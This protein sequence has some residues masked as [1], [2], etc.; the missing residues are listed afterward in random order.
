M[1]DGRERVDW[2]ASSE[3]PDIARG[4]AGDEELRRAGAI[5]SKEDFRTIG[6]ERALQEISRMTDRRVAGHLVNDGAGSRIPKPG[7]FGRMID[8]A[9]S[10]WRECAFIV[11]A[12]PQ[13][14]RYVRV[15]GAATN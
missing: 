2:T 1:Y 3:L 9:T 13:L 15:S 11:K 4:K 5:G 12:F 10:L 7:M 8:H 14:I 6:G